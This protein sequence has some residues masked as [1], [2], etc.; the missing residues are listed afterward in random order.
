MFRILVTDHPAPT[1]HLEAGIVQ[2]IGGELVIAERGDEEE[3]V[4]LVGDADAIL[5]CFRHV[6]PAVVRAGPKL[7]TIARY[8]VGVDNIAVDTATEL[9]IVVSNVP[10]YCVDEV[11]EHTIALLMTL[12]RKTAVYDADVRAGGWQIGVGMPI[13]RLAGSALGVVGFGHIGRGVTSRAIA[14]GMRVIVADPTEWP[15]AIRAAGAEPR[16]LDEL[17]A[18]ADAVTLHVPLRPETRNLI[19][20]ERLG[21][22]KPGAYLINC[23]R[24]GVVDHDALAEALEAGRLAGAGLD[25]FEPERLPADH[26][27]VGL[28]NTVLTPH[29][30]FYSEESIEE[31]QRRAAANVVAVLTGREPSNVVNPDAALRSQ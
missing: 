26:R 17:L 22:M 12:V 16:S 8:G 23:A 2:Q 28:R 31:L 5:T 19:D 24:G 27:L 21:R 10:V 13:H 18:E 29:V 1:T 30:A 25:V 11:A 9:G 20:A 14:L 4:S 3:L 7:R 15:E 6:T